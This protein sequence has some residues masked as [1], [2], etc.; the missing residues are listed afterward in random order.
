MCGTHASADTDTDTN[1]DT[2]INDGEA[3][4]TFFLNQGRQADRISS[5]P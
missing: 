1:T 5:A 3:C 2:V 4:A